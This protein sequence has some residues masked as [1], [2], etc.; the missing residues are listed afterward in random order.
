MPAGNP[1][2]Y[3]PNLKKRLKKAGAKTYKLRRNQKAAPPK[4]PMATIKSPNTAAGEGT[5]NVPQPTLKKPP[6]KPIN[7]A[8]PEMSVGSAQ[9]K[10]RSKKLG[11]L[12]PK[13]SSTKGKR[14]LSFTDAWLRRSTPS[15]RARVEELYGKKAG[16]KLR[17]K[18]EGPKARYLGRNK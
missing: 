15:S 16:A 10:A 5:A 18:A 3:L 4:P 2:G 1:A 6:A 8:A 11:S 17:R 7:F 9:Y 13:H 14:R 12:K